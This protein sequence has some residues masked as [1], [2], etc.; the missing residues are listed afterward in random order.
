MTPPRHG[1]PW[2]DDEVEI[3]RRTAHWPAQEVAAELGRGYAAVRKFRTTLGREE[4]LQFPNSSGF[5]LD[6][7]SVGKRTLLAKTCTRCGLLLPADW[8]GRRSDRGWRPHCV[9]CSIPDKEKQYD[10][11]KQWQRSNS[12]KASAASKAHYK[13]MQKIT[14]DRASRHG[15]PWNESDVPVLKDSSLSAFEKA[16]KLKRSYSSVR[17]QC[18]KE[19][20]S[21]KVGKGDPTL[22]RWIIDNPNEEKVS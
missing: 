19:G 17:N 9:R 5:Y 8:F 13:V 11:S 3:V 4:G 16:L 12:E 2:T 10:K 20:Y 7:Q 21:S 18:V 22:A 14:R 6:P 15:Y 1:Q